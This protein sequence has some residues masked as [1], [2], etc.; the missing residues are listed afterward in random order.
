LAAPVAF[1][2]TTS[3]VVLIDPA[4]NLGAVTIEH[5]GLGNTLNVIN[6]P[7]ADLPKAGGLG[8]LP[9]V[10]IGLFLVAMGGLYYRRTFRAATGVAS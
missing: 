2:V 5:K 1:K 9:N 8:P 3:N 7:V 4:A 10:L 6:S